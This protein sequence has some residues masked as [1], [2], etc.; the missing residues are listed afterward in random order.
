ML[1]QL[2]QAAG[3][4]AKQPPQPNP[5]MAKAQA[6]QQKTQADVQIAQ[7]QEKTKRM[8]VMTNAQLDAQ[9]L[10]IDQEANRIEAA[11]IAA[12]IHNQAKTTIHNQAIDQLDAHDQAKNSIHNHTMDRMDAQPD[13]LPIPIPVGKNGQM[14]HKA[15]V[16][17]A[18]PGQ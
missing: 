11:K 2:G 15:N 14:P 12:G 3:Q 6:I 8:D 18:M 9:R 4:K 7:E 10:Q 5:Q 17:V 13:V 16:I 1:T